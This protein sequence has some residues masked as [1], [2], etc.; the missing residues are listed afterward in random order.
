MKIEF[1]PTKDAINKVK[2]G[3]S[4]AM[5]EFLDWDTAMIE[6]DNRFGYGELRL[7]ATGLIDRKIYF[8]VFTET[9][10]EEIFRIISLR[11]ATKQEV[12]RYVH[13]IEK[14]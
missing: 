2:H 13:Y 1:D 5:A 7:T 4:L 3:I 14:W 11:N 10:Q 9:E 6:P 8:V 12:T